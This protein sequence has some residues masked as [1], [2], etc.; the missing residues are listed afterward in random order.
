MITCLRHWDSVVVVREGIRTNAKGVSILYTS[1]HLP[2]NVIMTT[3][4]E[5]LYSFVSSNSY[6]YLK[7][8]FSFYF[9]FPEIFCWT[10]FP[11]CGGKANGGGIVCPQLPPIQ[12]NSQTVTSSPSNSETNNPNMV[13]VFPSNHHTITNKLWDQQTQ[14]ITNMSKMWTLSFDMYRFSNIVHV[15]CTHSHPS[16]LLDTHFQ[17]TPLSTTST[18]INSTW[19][20][21]D[22]HVMELWEC[23]FQVAFRSVLCRRDIV[24]E[25]GQEIWN[26]LD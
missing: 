10:C 4:R 18:T 9:L 21:R 25:V 1:H 17:T 16:L 6:F 24:P 15:F 19:R 22:I 7:L 2:F 8:C 26:F 11:L 13:N 23:D 3:L 12:C 20:S 5:F 14:Y